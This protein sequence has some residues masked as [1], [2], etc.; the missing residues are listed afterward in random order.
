[1]GEVSGKPAGGAEVIGALA[2]EAVGALASELIYGALASGVTES[3][4][5]AST[6]LMVVGGPGAE[7]CHR[8]TPYIPYY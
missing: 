6:V 7:P 8:Y 3:P 5:E 2:S 4:T 1:M